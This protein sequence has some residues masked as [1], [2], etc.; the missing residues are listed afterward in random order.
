MLVE[1][2]A[3]WDH[4]QVRAEETTATTGEMTPWEV[5]PIEGATSTEVAGVE[6]ENLASGGED[7]EGLEVDTTTWMASEI[8]LFLNK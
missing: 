6:E 5:V 8:P 7:E 2:H 1:V 4:H 3:W